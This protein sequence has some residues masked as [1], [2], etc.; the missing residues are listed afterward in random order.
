MYMDDT[1]PNRDYLEYIV[2]E[3]HKTGIPNPF[4]YAFIDPN[5]MD[6]TEVTALEEYTQKTITKLIVESKDL[7]KD[8]DSYVNEYMAKG[9]NKLIPIMNEQAPSLLK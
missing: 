2:S 5:K 8:W 3:N 6:P 9:G 7:D 4:A 1:T